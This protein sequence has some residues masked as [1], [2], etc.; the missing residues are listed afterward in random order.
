MLRSV[1]SLAGRG[2]NTRKGVEL[3]NL[4]LTQARLIKLSSSTFHGH[5][6]Y[7][8]KIFLSNGQPDN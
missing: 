5:Q 7:E 4:A 2:E 1:D 8:T 3:E 6:D